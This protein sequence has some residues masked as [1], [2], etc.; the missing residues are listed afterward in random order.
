MLITGR[1]DNKRLTVLKGQLVPALQS[2]ISLHQIVSTNTYGTSSFCGTSAAAPHVA[3]AAALILKRHPEFNIAQL[4]AFLMNSATNKVAPPPENTVPNNIYGWGRLNLPEIYA[5]TTINTT[6]FMGSVGSTPSGIYCG[7][8]CQTYFDKNT[9]VTLTPLPNTG[10]DFTGWSG[11]GCAGMGTCTLTMASNFTVNASFNYHSTLSLTSP[12]GGQVW[13][14]GT[15]NPITWSYTGSPGST[16]QLDLIG[17]MSTTIASNVP[18]SSGSYT[19]TVPNSLPLSSGYRIKISSSSGYAG[20]EDTSDGSFTLYGL[21]V[22]SPYFSYWHR[23]WTYAITWTYLGNP[24]PYV[25]IELC[26]GPY[27]VGTITSS[28]SSGSGG[29]GTYNWRIPSNQNPSGPTYSI[30]VTSTGNPNY[31]AT[32]FPL[33]ITY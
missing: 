21:S 5:L 9:L 28:T 25:K 7:S 6:P 18:I 24:G 2:Q 1:Q 15:T 32:S 4:K 16:V 12:N 29:R 30:K 14:E 33:Y 26:Q 31:T 8:F 13:V 20:Y 19:W 10:Y 27:V 3:G 11:A 23:S 17:P 22:T